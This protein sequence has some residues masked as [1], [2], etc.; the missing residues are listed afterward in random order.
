MVVLDTELNAI[1]SKETHVLALY[2]Q[3]TSSLVNAMFLKF[4]RGPYV[5]KD[6]PYA[7]RTQLIGRQATYT[8]TAPICQCHRASFAPPAA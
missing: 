2:S 5:H 4:D 3:I 1:V 8:F 6:H 7:G